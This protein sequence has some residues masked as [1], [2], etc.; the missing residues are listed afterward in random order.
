MKHRSKKDLMTNL[1]RRISLITGFAVALGLM[2]GLSRPK[3]VADEIMPMMGLKSGELVNIDQQQ[4]GKSEMAMTMNGH[5]YMIDYTL[6]SNRSKQF[7]LLVQQEN[8]ELVEQAAPA[9][10]TI[11]GT[12]RGVEGSAVV[13]CITEK[14]CCAKIKFPSGDSCY[15]E[16]VSGTIDVPNLPGVHVVYT[17]DDV[18]P[19]EG[20]C[21]AE[22][23]SIEAELDSAG[24]RAFAASSTLQECELAVDADFEYFSIFGSTEATLARMELLI[25]IMNDQYESEVGI[26]HTI[27]TAVV[28]ATAN[29]PYTTSDPNALL[30]QLR[31]VYQPTG[32]DGDLC[33]LFTGKNLNGSTI[34]IAFVGGVCSNRLGFGLSQNESPISDMTDLLA[35]EIGH[36]WNQSH[37]RCQSHTMNASLTGANDFNDTLTV[38]NLISYRDA[39]NCLDSITVPAN[40]NLTNEILIDDLDFSVTG[41][42]IA[43]TTEADEPNLVEAGSSVWWY[44]D[45]D[46]AGTITIDT[47]G[48]DF[49]TQLY[50]YEFMS[51]GGLA[52]LV[53]IDENDD[54]DFDADNIQSEVAF[55]VTAGTRYAIR[56]GG[57]R[58][59]GSI[60]DGSEGNIALNGAFV[61]SPILLGDVNINGEV[62][63]ADIGP[64]IT[65]LGQSGAYQIEADTNE[66]DVVSFADIGPFITILGGSQ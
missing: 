1:L 26:R 8:G 61:P 33:H 11:R 12:L 3:D 16:P 27:S 31:A 23:E 28:R 2:A 29:D 41:S 53:L 43:A 58:D 36:N 48:S 57:F 47:I 46:A 59:A 25:N 5:D 15:I 37:C 38:P 55:A 51:G 49:D 64:F 30:N 62:S 9:V 19:M 4:V 24:A 54:I 17:V 60:G 21:G 52:G 65:L 34:G 18:I 14:G 7:R 13:G 45:A 44:V 42:N 39:L 66:D 20:K 56:V 63:F 6:H 50:A 32:F 22:A 35:H 40:D 10:S